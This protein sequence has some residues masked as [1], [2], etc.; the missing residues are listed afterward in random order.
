MKNW[1]KPGDQTGR[2]PISTEICTG[3]CLAAGHSH[4]KPQGV[5]GPDCA[6]I[7]A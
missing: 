5:S 6:I 4:G 1:G 7:R 3:N 2:L